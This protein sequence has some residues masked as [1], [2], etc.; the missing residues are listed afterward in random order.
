MESIRPSIGKIRS[1]N[2]IFEVLSYSHY[3]TDASI[4]LFQGSKQMRRMLI[5]NYFTILNTLI[6]DVF[7]IRQ[8]PL[9]SKNSE[10]PL[11]PRFGVYNLDLDLNIGLDYLKD[12][13]SVMCP[14]PA[15]RTVTVGAYRPIKFITGVL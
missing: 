2:L 13:F 8:L 1:K 15:I 4:F 9:D 3:L 7:S 11:I 5:E 10:P 14:L 12:V 6:P